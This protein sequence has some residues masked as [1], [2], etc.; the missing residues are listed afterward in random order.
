MD[1]EVIKPEQLAAILLSQ[2]SLSEKQHEGV[3]PRDEGSLNL[4]LFEQVNQATSC[5][6]PT[7]AL[8]VP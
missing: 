2:Q 3:E 6:K 7:P 5:A 8:P 1:L 4:T